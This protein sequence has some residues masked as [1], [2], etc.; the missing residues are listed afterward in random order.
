M[1][2]RE[3][4]ER[5]ERSHD[6]FVK[7]SAKNWIHYSLYWQ[8]FVVDGAIWTMKPGIS[9][10]LAVKNEKKTVAAKAYVAL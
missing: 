5:L 7:K 6:N 9:L 1:Y 10:I 2:G 3:E 8:T 4:V